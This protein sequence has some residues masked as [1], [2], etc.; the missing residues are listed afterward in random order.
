MTSQNPPI[1]VRKPHVNEAHGVKWDDPWHWLRDPNYPD[2]QDADVLDYL[3]AENAYFDAWKQPHDE[4]VE[5]L[6]Q[7]M[8]GRIKED[9]ASVPIKDGDWLYWSAF[10]EG[11]QYRDWYRKAVAGGDDALIYSENAEAEGKEY[12]RLGAFA[13]SPDGKL[14]ATLVDDDG[15]ERFKL[16]VRDL[17]TGKDLATVSKVGIG[18]PVWTNDSKGLVFTEVND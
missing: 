14:L 11:T 4:L 5:E 18:N 10:K 8:K 3:K 15:S 17:G 13:V 2:V 1:A 9:D 12:Y 7:E 6:F 16:V